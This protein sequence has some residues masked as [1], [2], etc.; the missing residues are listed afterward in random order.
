[1]RRNLRDDDD[2]MS[3]DVRWPVYLRLKID[4]AVEAEAGEEEAV[5]VV[6]EG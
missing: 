2:G 5:G 6:V 1:M 4:F 3:G